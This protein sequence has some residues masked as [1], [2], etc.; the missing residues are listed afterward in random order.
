MKKL[1]LLLA[2]AFSGLSLSAQS[3]NALY[4][5]NFDDHVTVPNASAVIANSNAISMTM[6]IY[7]E[8]TAP[9]FPDYDG[10]GGF[11][12]NSNADFFFL[13]LTAT[14]V[15]ARFRNSAGI[16]YDIVF[17]G[18]VLNTWQHFAMT[19][20]GATLTL[21]HNGVVAGSVAATGTIS[22]AFE[23]FYLGK[24]DEASL[25]SKALSP[26]EIACMY[27][28]AIDPTS[29]NLELYYRFN[30]GVAGGVNGAVN[31]L[32]DA[33]GSING[34]LNNFTLSGPVSNWVP[35]VITAN[36]SVAADVICPGTTYTFG[37]Q[38][39][40]T[41]GNYYEA[42]PT[43][44]GCDSIAQL[45]LTTVTFNAS[46]S[47][48]G[49]VLTANQL[50]AAYQWIDCTNGNLAIAGATN[51]TYTATANGQYA[52]ILTLGGCSDTT[53]CATV[54]NVGLND[55]QSAAITAS[56]N[57]FNDYITLSLPASINNK[58]VIVYDVTGREV[59]NTVSNEKQL[60]ISTSSWTASVYY[61][62]I[63]GVAKR[64]KL[65][66]Q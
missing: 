59:Y 58:Q 48:V 7:P 1:V 18:L 30:Q 40:T 27:T 63:E 25:W 9:T 56:P 6:W 16:A 29:T 33:T 23:T 14:N 54:T 38:T 45:V 32:S 20:D 5:D 3:D 46:I 43:S 49:P 13:Q 19:Y 42:F 11:R 60:V 57:P 55:L 26:A 24:I 44:G 35:G 28:G 65:I 36:S 34:T 10:F 4:F 17:T 2:C 47:Q 51:Q 37:S 21:Y 66:K 62:S 53:V 12:N 64:V 15:E 22:S 39:I 50:G 41:P 61:V 31:T 8:N 52:V